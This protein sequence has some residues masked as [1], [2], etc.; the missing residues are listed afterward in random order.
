MSTRPRLVR[1]I[2]FWLL[3]V[4]S[5]AL[6]AVGAWLVIDRVGRIQAGVVAQTADGAIE[7]YAGP[8]IAI[9]GAVVLGAGIVGVLLTL[10]VAA[11]STLRPHA[12]ADVVEPID[13]DADAHSDT[14]DDV[15]TGEHGYQRGLGYT[16]AIDTTPAS[17]EPAEK[18]ADNPADEGSVAR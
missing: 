12:P 1:S 8:S 5:L 2:P 16:E 4:V 9:A 18:P 7:V 11:A 10:A 15:P 3:L 14:G 17:G 6:T 13:G